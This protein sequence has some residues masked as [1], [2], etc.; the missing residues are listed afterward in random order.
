MQR[1]RLDQTPLIWLF[2]LFAFIVYEAL[3]M[4]YLFLP[5]LFGLLF[6][7][8]I[9]A[10][11]HRK[12]LPFF[13]VLTM[14]IIAESAKGYLL[15]ST[16]FFFTLSYFTVLPRFKSAVSCRL[17][18]NGFIVAYAYLGYFVFA[19]L[20]SQM[21]ALPAPHLDY[22]VIFYMAIEFFLTGLL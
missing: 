18:L 7:L 1:N 16:V 17:C 12:S 11:E 20:I 15:L 19:L 14:L 13:A 9:R 21:F 4:R 8:Y 10:L 2:Y 22:R 3:A 5:P 6:F